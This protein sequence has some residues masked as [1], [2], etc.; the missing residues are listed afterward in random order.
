M[1]KHGEV[2]TESFSDFETAKKAAYYDEEGYVISD[3]S[4]KDKLKKPVK[5]VNQPCPDLE[6]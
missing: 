1:I 2:T 3:E 5:I 6:G 4:N